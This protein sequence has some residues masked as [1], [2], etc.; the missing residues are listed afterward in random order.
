MKRKAWFIESKLDVFDFATCDKCGLLIKDVQDGK[1]F[2]NPNPRAYDRNICRNCYEVWR[3]E[4]EE[5]ARVWREKY[6][7]LDSANPKSEDKA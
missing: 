3:H 1:C 4:R 6:A 5:R 2:W 7:S